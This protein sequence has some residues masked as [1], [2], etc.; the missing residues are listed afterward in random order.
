M[1]HSQSNSG[2]GQPIRPEADSNKADKHYIENHLKRDKEQSITF[3]HRQKGYRI[4]HRTHEHTEQRE[5]RHSHCRHKT[6]V[7]E[8]RHKQRHRYSKSYQ[9]RRLHQQL[10]LYLFINHTV[11]VPD[12]RGNT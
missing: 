8:H 5:L 6:A 3:H 12:I 4:C 9:E 1:S 2:T 11:T 10:H 7:I